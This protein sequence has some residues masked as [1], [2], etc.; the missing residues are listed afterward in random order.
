MFVYGFI[1]FTSW[2]AQPTLEE[3]VKEEIKISRAK[4]KGDKMRKMNME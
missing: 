2:L 4:A 3:S 1:M